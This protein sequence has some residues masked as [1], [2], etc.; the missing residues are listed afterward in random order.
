MGSV[1]ADE[2]KDTDSIVIDGDVPV[3]SVPGPEEVFDDT[4]VTCPDNGT[5][6]DVSVSREAV[7]TNVPV[8]KDPFVGISSVSCE[9]AGRN[10]S[11]EDPLV[12]TSVSSEIAVV[13]SDPAAGEVEDRDS[14]TEDISTTVDVPVTNEDNIVLV[15]VP[16]IVCVIMEGEVYVLVE[17]TVVAVG[18]VTGTIDVIDD[19][20]AVG[21]V[22]KDF[23]T[24]LEDLMSEIVDGILVVIVAVV[25]D[26]IG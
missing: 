11:V 1:V 12:D 4:D 14:D 24:D 19:A 6:F 21:T 20:D 16:E 7:D 23:D 25:P 5:V 8:D 15:S 17:T 2:T 18:D 26:V 13:W 9:V 10:V 3:C 22:V